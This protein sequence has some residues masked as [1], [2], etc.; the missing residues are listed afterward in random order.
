MAI[1]IILV[2]LKISGNKRSDLFQKS[3]H[4]NN[5]RM[6]ENI[7]KID[8]EV[9]MR[10]LHDNSEWDETVKYIGKPAKEFETECL[11]S[12]LPTF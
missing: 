9:F 7:L 3:S 6:V 12:L 11:N 8:R 10:P 5:E 4:A 2:V 1:I